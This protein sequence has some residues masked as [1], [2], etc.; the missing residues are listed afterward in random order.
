MPLF[1]FAY[2]YLFYST[3]TVQG[4]GA[5]YYFSVKAPRGRGFPRRREVPQHHFFD[6]DLCRRPDYAWTL[7]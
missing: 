5:L 2:I 4:A 1:R 7:A 6:P 3:L